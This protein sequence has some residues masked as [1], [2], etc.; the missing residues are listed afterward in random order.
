MSSQMKNQNF[1]EFIK[2]DD[3]DF[4]ENYLV[5][6]SEREIDLFFHDNPDFMESYNINKDRRV[7]LRD[8]M[9]RGILKRIHILLEIMVEVSHMVRKN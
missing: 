3:I 8:K 5:N 4:Y 7:L 1:L 2:G 9:Y 6:L